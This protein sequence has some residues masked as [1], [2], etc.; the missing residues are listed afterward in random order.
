MDLSNLGWIALSVIGVILVVVIFLAATVK[1]GGPKKAPLDTLQDLSLFED[2]PDTATYEIDPIS[3]A[4]VYLA[5]GNKQQA[6][7]L[8]R[9]A[10]RLH[11]ERADIR[12]K[13]L[14]IE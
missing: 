5:Y 11:P 12:E 2:M 8:L 4:E 3:E 6:L 7:S 14:E 9:K 1:I 10:A 13:I